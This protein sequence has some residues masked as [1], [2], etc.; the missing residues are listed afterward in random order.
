[1]T[2]VARSRREAPPDAPS[3]AGVGEFL[4]DAGTSRRRDGRAP[5]RARFR[6]PMPLRVT[7]VALLTALVAVAL[8]LTGIATSALLENSARDQRNQQL[9]ETLARYEDR[10]WFRDGCREPRWGS[11]EASIGTIYVACLTFEG[12]E[13]TLVPAPPEPG[14][15]PPV[16]TRGVVAR[17]LDDPDRPVFTEARDG[18]NWLLVDRDL[19]NGVVAIAGID[20]DSDDDLLRQLVA[21]QVVVGLVVLA[22]LAG[23]ASVLVRN[24]LR[25]LTEVER[26]AAAIAAGDLSQ[27]V[28]AADD[29]TEVGRLARALNGML[30]RIEHGFRAQQASEEQA[31]A[32]ETRMRRFVADASHELRTPLTSIRGFAEL[33]RQGAVGSPEETARLMQRIESEGARMGL[34][35]EDLLQLARLDQQRPLTIT[36]VDL[37][38]VA[39]DAVHDARVVQPDRPITLHVDEALS[40]LP[41]VLGDEARLRQVVGNLVTNALVHTPPTAALTVTVSDEPAPADAA[42]DGEDGGMVVLRVADQGPGM[43]P[44]H[45]ARVFERFYRADASRARTAGGTGLGLA[46]VSALVAAHGGTVHLDTAPGRGAVFTVRLPRS[47]PGPAA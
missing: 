30:S 41:V 5:V 32:S 10:P 23:A 18:T 46:I 11:Q 27:R 21:F 37:A 4:Q 25:P 36:P 7:L 15:S 8:T 26:T 9:N 13:P 6:R 33:Y 14:V 40:E 17:L 16:I 38:E 35:V 1:M 39:G 29:R 2:D 45:A 44:E 34:L 47:G 31:R 42:P 28:P 22:L 20:L 43:A 3:P 19:G 24:S 12:G